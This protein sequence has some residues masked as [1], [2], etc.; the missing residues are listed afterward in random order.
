MLAGFA[1][2]RPWAIPAVAALW[3]GMEYA[4]GSLGLAWIGLGF[5][6]LNLG[7][8]AIDMPFLPLNDP[9]G[10]DDECDRV[11]ALGF[12]GKLVIH[13]SHVDG[14]IAGFSPSAAQIEEAQGILDAFE[15]ANGNACQY[16]GKM[17]DE[18]VFHA[19]RRVLALAQ[20]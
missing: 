20:R 12:T 2:R 8:A 15:R 3:A 7:N 1:I 10:L 16:K 19:A 9:V 14:A 17:I 6:W 11:R 4:H 5:A 18:P 13:P